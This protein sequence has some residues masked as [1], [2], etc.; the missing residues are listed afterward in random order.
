MAKKVYLTKVLVQTCWVVVDEDT[1]TATEQMDTGV[2]VQASQWPDFYEGWS[3]EFETL[4][5]SILKEGEV[6]A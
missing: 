6:D 1:G 4:K 5:E 2:V 3:K